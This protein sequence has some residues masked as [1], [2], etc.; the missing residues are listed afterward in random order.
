MQFWDAEVKPGGSYKVK[1]EY[2]SYF[3]ITEAVLAVSDVNKVK[4]KGGKKDKPVYVYMKFKDEKRCLGSLSPMTSIKMELDLYCHVEV[5]LCH[6]SKDTSVYFYGLHVGPRYEA[7]DDGGYNDFPFTDT[8]ESSEEEIEPIHEGGHWSYLRYWSAKVNP[9]DPFKCKPKANSIL[10]LSQAAFK[11]EE[12]DKPIYIYVSADG[13]EKELLGTLSESGCQQIPFNL[14][15]DKEFELSHNSNKASVY[16]L[17]HEF[18]RSGRFHNDSGAEPWKDMHYWSVKVDPGCSRTVTCEVS[19]VV[20]LIHASLENP[21]D[22][23]Y[24]GD[25]DVLI[26]LKFAWFPKSVIGS[27]SAMKCTQIHFNLPFEQDIELSHSSKNAS[28]CFLGYVVGQQDRELGEVEVPVVRNGNDRELGDVEVPIVRNGNGAHVVKQ[29]QGEMSAGKADVDKEEY[30]TSKKATK[31][32]AATVDEPMV[33]EDDDKDDSDKESD[34]DKDATGN[35]P[36][37]SASKTHVLEENTE[38]VT[39]A[40]GQ[41]SGWDGNSDKPKEHSSNFIISRRSSPPNKAWETH[42]FWSARVQ[43][44]MHIEYTPEADMIVHLSH[45]SLG[46]SKDDGDVHIYVEVDCDKSLIGILSPGK[47]TQIPLNLFLH[48][49]FRLSH[50]KNTCVYFFGDEC[51][52]PDEYGSADYSENELDDEDAPGAK[53][54]TGGDEKSDT[55]KKRTPESIDSELLKLHGRNFDSETVL[56]ADKK[57]KRDEQL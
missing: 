57:A 29:E 5:E 4:S 11:P 36:A 7:S 38:V 40:G 25:E 56:P 18:A 52:Q 1:P 23:E 9:G 37:E 19:T 48:K 2:Y 21:G 35:Q 54:A 53:N 13:F 15:F 27:L 28:V 8:E 3:R 6:S 33:E 55:S 10:H 24:V 22:K 45:A 51:L 26:Y 46:K 31:H 50:S 41:K 17:G 44:G 43:G 30:S 47:C 20:Q 32:E 16:F 49:S 34:D 12:D 14:H 42:L 39:P